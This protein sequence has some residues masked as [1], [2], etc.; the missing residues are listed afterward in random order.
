MG[1]YVRKAQKLTV[2]MSSAIATDDMLGEPWTRE[3][4]MM[5]PC[6][7]RFL[8][9]K[10]P[11]DTREV[12]PSGETPSQVLGLQDYVTQCW[13]GSLLQ[14]LSLLCSC[15]EELKD[16]IDLINIFNH[17]E[18]KGKFRSNK[19]SES[20]E[21]VVNKQGNAYVLMLSIHDEPH[22]LFET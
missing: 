22:V 16:C 1:S 19:S 4:C 2:L 17:K 18:G 11:L 13:T 8:V 5:T 7:E 9:E 14:K 6:S 20:A 15:T 3:G 21:I 10:P 12:L